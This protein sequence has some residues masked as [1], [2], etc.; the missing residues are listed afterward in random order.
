M[1]K[2]GTSTGSR[3]TQFKPGQSGNPKGRPRKGE[4]LTEILREQATI[5]DVAR[6]RTKIE[7]QAAIAD[8]LW[9]LAIRG[10]IAA[11]KYIYDRLDGSPVQRTENENIELP[12]L[13]VEPPDDMPGDVDG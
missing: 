6:G 3:K 12:P 9:T 4:S 10:D 5:K 7:R 8:K 1:A 11:I 13:I 2:R